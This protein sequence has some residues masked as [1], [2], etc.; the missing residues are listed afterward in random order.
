MSAYS[1]DHG[2]Q[3][4]VTTCEDG[5]CSLWQAETGE[6][7]TSLSM[8]AGTPLV[9][10][11]TAKTCS[12]VPDHTVFNLTDPQ[13]RSDIA[14]ACAYMPLCHNSIPP[15]VACHAGCQLCVSKRCL[16]MPL[17][18]NHC[19]P[20]RSATRFGLHAGSICK[21]HPC[22]AVHFGGRAR[23][24]VHAAMGAGC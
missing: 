18:L 19:L 9:T 23:E 1:G 3:V 7:I 15:A 14:S 11:A 12:Q 21:K 24:W 5:T 6:H 20:V 13:L 17:L 2:V 10:S 8:P 16:C 4:L 22:G